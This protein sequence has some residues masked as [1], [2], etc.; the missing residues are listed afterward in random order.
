M[1]WEGS[2]AGTSVVNS[3][4]TG[5]DVPSTDQSR[6]RSYKIYTD[7]HGRQWGAIIENRTG[8]PCGPLEAQFHAPVLP[9]DKF[10]TINSRFNKLTIRYADIILDIQDANNDWEASLRE[11][12][13]KMYGMGAAAV[14]Q[15]PTPEL[16]D[17]VGP[18]PKAHREIWEAAMQDNKWILGFDARKPAWAEEFFPAASAE[19]QKREVVMTRTY[20]DADEDEPTTEKYPKWSG[21]KTGWQ[22]SDGSYVD[23]LEGED[24]DA[25]KTRAE[26]AEAGL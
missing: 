2:D 26:Q 10:V 14:I 4:G 3:G 18:R 16:L 5:G 15:S 23:R 24:K 9:L 7:Q 6:K 19:Q 8:D 25:Y 11:H 20:P 13:R 1:A 22:L 12:A 17:L 21:P